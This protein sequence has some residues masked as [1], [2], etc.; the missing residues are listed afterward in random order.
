[1]RTGE[2]ILH[3]VSDELYALFTVLQNENPTLL[4]VL[5]SQPAESSILA[6]TSEEEASAGR[7]SSSPT[8]YDIKLWWFDA[9]G[10]VLISNLVC[11]YLTSSSNVGTSLTMGGHR[12]PYKRGKSH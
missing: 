10:F 7:D 11:N 12:D 4:E 6:H 3:N 1:M 9:D 2:I 5:G 8:A